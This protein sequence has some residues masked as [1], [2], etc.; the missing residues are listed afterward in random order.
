[1]GG[2][3]YYSCFF[4][5]CWLRDFFN[6]ARS[7]LVQITASFSSIPFVIVHV[8]HPNNSIN[9]T[10]SWK[11]LFFIL[12]G[13]S[14]FHITDRQSI[15]VHAFAS[16][17]WISFVVDETLLPRLVNLASSFRD[18]PF[19]VEMSPLWLQHM[20]SVLSAFTLKPTPPAARS[21]LYSRD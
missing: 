3:W 8:V 2:R 6:P 9:T 18:P 19:S 11:K 14:D 20:N 15:A 4:G 13:R 17:V 21:R 1:M 5:R 10:A 16:H 12:W 7:I